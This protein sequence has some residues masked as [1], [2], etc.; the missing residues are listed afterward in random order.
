MGLIFLEIGKSCIVSQLSVSPE[1]F[2]SPSRGHRIS[3]SYKI[4]MMRLRVVA[5]DAVAAVGGYGCGAYGL[6]NCGFAGCWVWS[7]VRLW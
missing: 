1:F 7:W 3:S 5:V 2:L 6:C 4:L